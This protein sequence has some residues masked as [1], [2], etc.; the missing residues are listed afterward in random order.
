MALFL[1]IDPGVTTGWA[2]FANGCLYQCGLGATWA[3]T[4]QYAPIV[5][6]KPQV[7]PHTGAKEANDLIDLAIMVGEY[8]RELGP[9]GVELVR[10][11]AWKGNTPKHV[12]HNRVRRVL[13]PP[14]LTL[15]GPALEYLAA[16]E[17]ATEGLR[18]P[19]TGRWHNLL[20]AVGLGLW[21]LGRL[22]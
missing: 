1:A 16:C 4:F 18:K 9:D 14:E 19:P 7:Y 21:K 8:K 5:I 10:P 6:E 15:L 22:R 11:H 20:D 17:K 3:R 2:S 12:H 13:L